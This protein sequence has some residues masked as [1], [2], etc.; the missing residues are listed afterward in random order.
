MEGLLYTNEKVFE[1]FSEYLPEPEQERMREIFRQA[2]AALI[3][4]TLE[5]MEAAMFDLNAVAQD[6]A[7]VMLRSTSDG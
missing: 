6:L 2:L 3:A 1:Q 7:D 4:D 5:D